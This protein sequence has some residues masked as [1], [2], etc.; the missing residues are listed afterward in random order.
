MSLAGQL[1]TGKMKYKEMPEG[2]WITPVHKKFKMI[3]CDCGLVH[4][5][6][7]RLYNR[8]IQIKVIRNNCSTSN[9]RRAK[10]GTA[11]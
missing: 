11:N 6:D 8:K 3:C 4:D 2:E 5:V 9:V 1:G 7:F 10:N